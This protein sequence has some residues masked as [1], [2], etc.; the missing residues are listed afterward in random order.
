MDT[1]YVG[2]WPGIDS[3]NAHDF[4]QTRHTLTIHHLIMIIVQCVYNPARTEERLSDVNPV[5][6]SH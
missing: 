3:L 4:H 1:P 5:D 2:D 6:Q